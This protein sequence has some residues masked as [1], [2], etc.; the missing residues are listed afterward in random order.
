MLI[1]RTT[2]N[3]RSA[4]HSHNIT[5]Y[6]RRNLLLLALC[7]ALGMSVM[8]ML[9]SAGGLVGLSLSPD[10]AWSTL[11]AGMQ[12]LFTMLATLPAS[13]L[14]QRKGRRYGFL[15]ACLILIVAALGSSWAIYQSSFS[16]FVVSMMG[17]GVAVSFFQFFRFAAIDIAPPHYVSKAVSWVL[18]GGLLAAFIGPNLAHWTHKLDQQHPFFYTMLFTIPIGLIMIRLFRRMDLPLPD[19]QQQSGGQ[20]PLRVILCQPVFIVAVS[21]AMIAY[22]VMTLLMT[23]TPL[24]MKGHGFNFG[25]T[26]FIIQW[27]LVGMFGP[28]FFSGSL[29]NHFG[30]LQ[31]ML[32]GVLAYLAVVILNLSIQSMTGYW[33]ALV[34]LGVGWNFLFIGATTLLHEAWLP[35]EM[36]RVQ[37]INDTLVYSISSIAAMSSG[38]LYSSAGWK[39]TNLFSLPL[40]LVAGSLIIY[41]MVK[42]RPGQ[43]V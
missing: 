36:G 20:R 25:Q 35:A 9:L 1:C 32:L 17:F 8:S 38:I 13:L 16:G 24:A 7:Q 37:G 43:L 30:V 31:V 6:M 33:L 27:H 14:M 2:G 11:P 18:A 22:G 4:G 34:L 41:L 21:S 12:L 10:P 40:S 19:R 23:A 5:I 26:A 28:S 3:G 15:L 29:I 39:M 42:R